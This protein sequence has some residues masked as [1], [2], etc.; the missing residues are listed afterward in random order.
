MTLRHVNL[1]RFVLLLLSWYDMKAE[2]SMQVGSQSGT[3]G[4][5]FWFLLLPRPHKTY[6]FTVWNQNLK[7]LQTINR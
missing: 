4:M 1:I 6:C 5:S 3:G 7:I 2:E